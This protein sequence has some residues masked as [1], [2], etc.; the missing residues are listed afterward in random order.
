M[1]DQRAVA[2]ALA[3]QYV[4]EFLMA[5]GTAAIVQALA[6]AERRGMLTAAKICDK[7]A[8][9]YR[10]IKSVGDVSDW[11]ADSLAAEIRAQATQEEG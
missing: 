3:E 11:V 1:T 8:M 9:Y 2:E 4:D 5:E 7:R 6:D 10:G